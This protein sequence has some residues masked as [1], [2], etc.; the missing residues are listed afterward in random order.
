VH[1]QN[2]IFR[3]VDLYFPTE[4]YPFY[5]Y[6]FINLMQNFTLCAA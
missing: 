1:R 5:I 4:I 6:I 2:L 3:T